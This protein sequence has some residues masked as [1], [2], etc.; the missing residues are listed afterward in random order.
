M[1]VPRKITRCATILLLL[2]RVER[3]ST[4]CNDKVAQQIFTLNL[5]CNNVARFRCLYYRTLKE[6]CLVFRFRFRKGT[7][8]C[9]TLMYLIFS[10]SV[11][12]QL[13]KGRAVEAE[14][15][16]QVSIYFSDIVG[17]TS[18]SAESTPMQVCH[19]IPRIY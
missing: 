19:V 12:E 3:A 15:F 17:F 11:A 7:Q 4:L 14:S 16:N 9:F 1:N 2:Q 5:Q 18:L 6:L 13:K 8:K 10:R